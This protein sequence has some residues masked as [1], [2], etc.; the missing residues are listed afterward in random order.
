MR[1]GA[2][3]RIMGLLLLMAATAYSIERFVLLPLRCSRAAMAAEAELVRA[4]AQ[5]EY[6]AR[7]AARRV[8]G[9]MAGCECLSPRNTQVLADVARAS[10]LLGDDR[11]AVA[12][13]E[14]ALAVD[15]RPRLYFQLGMARLRMLDRAGAVADLARA[16]AFDPS[17]LDYIEDDDL[18]RETEERL[19]A[20]NYM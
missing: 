6:V 1:S 14:R 10:S 3:V 8:L 17:L 11:S 9:T 20:L 13:F 4:A 12:A 2:I 7:R 16:C 15:R 19:R 5:P 18:R